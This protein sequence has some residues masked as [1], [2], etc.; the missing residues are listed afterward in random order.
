MTLSRCASERTFGIDQGMRMIN[1]KR[2]TAEKVKQAHHS[3][4]REQRGEK[5]AH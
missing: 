3:I 2:A 1:S 5:V 4:E